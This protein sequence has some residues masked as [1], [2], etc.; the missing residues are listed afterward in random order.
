MFPSCILKNANKYIYISK[1][2][3]KACPVYSTSDAQP[4]TLSLP[5]WLLPVFRLESPQGKTYRSCCLQNINRLPSNHLLQKA[6]LAA[7][8]GSERWW[9]PQG[10]QHPEFPP[11]R[12]LGCNQRSGWS[13]HA[14]RNWAGELTEGPMGPIGPSVPGGPWRAKGDISSAAFLDISGGW[15]GGDNFLNW[16][17]L[18]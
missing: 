8:Q 17:L 14:I 5:F 9:R 15:N 3:T 4:L 18:T 16:Q 11:T 2:I 12:C 13:F 10:L 6:R 1:E 7:A